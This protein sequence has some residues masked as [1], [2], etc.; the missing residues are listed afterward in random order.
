MGL[1][2]WAAIFAGNLA[3]GVVLPP[4]VRS[5]VIAA[6]A[7]KPG[8]DAAAAA[9]M[10]WRAEG[11]KVRIER[12]DKPGTDFNDLLQSRGLVAHA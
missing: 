12:P 2:P 11:R 6:D 7:D 3:R 10:R 8:L 5:V 9:A 4:E 1:P